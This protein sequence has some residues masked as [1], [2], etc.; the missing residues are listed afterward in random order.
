MFEQLR[1]ELHGFYLQ[2]DAE[3]SRAF[4]NKCFAILDEKYTNGMSVTAQKLLQYDVITEHFEPKI[5]R[6]SPY[7]YETGVLTSL[8]DGAR[9]AKGHGFVQANGWVF[10]RNQHLF[11]EQDEALYQRRRAHMREKLYLIC[12]PYNDTEQHFN[13]NCRPFLETGARGIYERAQAEIANAETAEEREFFQSVCHGMRTLRRM[14][15]RF[16]EAAGEMLLTERDGGVRKNLARIAETAKRIPWEA[17]QSLYEALATLAFLRTAMGSLEGA[18]PNTFGRLDRDLIGFYRRDLSL[19]RLTQEEAYALICH[20]LLIWDCHYDH[21]MPM[22]GYADHELEN[23]YTLGGCD[24][25]GAPLFNELT[26]LFLRATREQGIIFPKI[27]CRFSQSSPKEYLDEINRSIVNGTSTVLLQNDDA[28][29]PALVRAGRPIREAR[30][31]M[32]AGCWDL[33]TNQEKADRG[34]YLNLLK[35]FEYSIHGLTEK[36]EAVG[37]LFE[38]L[39][40]CRDF[41]DVYQTTLRNCERLLDAKLDVQTRGGQILH[42][43]DRLPIFSSTLEGCLESRRDFTEGGGKYNDDYQLL[44]GFPNIVDSLMAI[45]TLVFDRKSYTL[46]EYLRA[47]R[48]NWEGYEDARLEA[49]ACHGWGDGNEDSCALANRFNND[50]YAIFARKIGMHGGKVHMGHLTY[51]EIRWWGEH[52]L[53]TPD[54]RRSGEY[55]AQGLTPSRLKRI[56]CVN[57]VINSLAALDPSTLAANSVVNIILPGRIPL[58]RCEGFLRAMAGTAIQSLQL[59]CTTKEELLDAQKHPEDYPHLIVRVTGFSA[60]FT[61]LSKG[62]QDEVISRNFYE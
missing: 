6:H 12:G 27:K 57:D 53:A 34:S 20:F 24:D 31:Y 30:D 23:T 55:F 41:E 13:F 19:G 4:A 45:K 39:E 28:T 26:A 56:P 21:D 51:T 18:G 36:M 44:F 14:A 3:R 46:A 15:E 59:N 10:S 11:I 29:I 7:F 50:L 5:F 60:K 40:I 37:I 22:E 43:V 52:T 38:P 49:V 8:S 32:I 42:Q 48:A 16:S 9:D 58:N 35:P 62:W 17:P 2:G 25:L 33:V 47:V 61:S 1:K 54:G